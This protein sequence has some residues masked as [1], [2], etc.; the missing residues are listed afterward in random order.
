MTVAIADMLAFV[1][2]VWCAL[3]IPREAKG[4]GEQ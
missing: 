4:E 1:S 3:A 2:C